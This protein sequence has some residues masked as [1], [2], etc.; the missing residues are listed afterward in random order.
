MTDVRGRSRYSGLLWSAAGALA[1]VAAWAL[2]ARAVDSPIILPGPL[3]TLAV[4]GELVRSER[5]HAAL[6]GSLIRV[7][8]GIAIAVPSALCVG[9]AAGLDSRVRAFFRPLFSFISATP[10]LSLILI[11]FLWFGQDRTPVFA[12]FLM[13]FPV[14]ASNTIEGIRAA[15]GR[16]EEALRIYGLSRTERLR[17]LYIPTL[18]PFIGAGLR[19]S[20]ALCWKVTVAEEVMVQPGR[21]LGTGMQRAKAQL[22]TPEL[23]AWTAAT[24]LAAAL[25][26][27]ILSLALRRRRGGGAL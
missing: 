11:A 1:L 12:S 8:A 21:A 13:V 10:V 20:L 18:A 24:I 15:D 16:L 17:H 22:E 5:F 7:A 9:I 3:P 6:G 4:L 19:S 23:F 25:T 2:A 27:L 26:E 14:M